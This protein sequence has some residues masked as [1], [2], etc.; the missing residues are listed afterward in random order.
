[1]GSRP[2][3]EW[4]RVTLA[5]PAYGTRVVVFRRVDEARAP[6][7]GEAAP[8]RQIAS[9]S[10]AVAEEG[11][12]LVAENA[13][14]RVELANGLIR[15]LSTLSRTSLLGSMNITEGRR[16][17]WPG[18]RLNFAKSV[19][20][21]PDVKRE[22]GKTIITFKGVLKRSGEITL[23][24]QTRYTLDESPVMGLD[25]V[26][27][28]PKS[29]RPVRGQLGMELQ[30]GEAGE[31][32]VNTIE[33]QLR[34]TYAVLHP[35]GDMRRGYR[36]WHRSGL[37][38]ESSL[39]PLDYG[40][41]VVAAKVGDRWL[42]VELPPLLSGFENAYLRERSG[43]GDEGLTL[44]LGWLEEKGRADLSKPVRASLRLRVG[45]MPGEPSGRISGEGWRFDSVSSR[46]E[47]RNEQYELAISRG[48]GGKMVHLSEPGG[49]SV[50]VSTEVYS[51]KGIY[52]P[53]KNSIGREVKTQGSSKNDFEPDAFLVRR[54]DGLDMTF[55]SFL[56]MSYW[57]WANVASPR[58]QYEV[59]YGLGAS[60]KIRARCRVRPMLSD[61]KLAAFLAQT[62]HI[63]KARRWSVD[64]TAGKKSGEAS[65]A[66][67][68][69]RVWQS[70]EAPL[71]RDGSLQIELLDGRRLTFSAIHA[72]P[73]EVQNVFLL[74]SGGNR[75]ILFIAFFDGTPAKYRPSWRSADY[76]MEL[77]KP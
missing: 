17:I 13:F 19:E 50:I 76:T 61:A 55:N 29:R 47:F 48:L 20:A 40:R 36:Y 24:W 9:K 65:A 23:P 43:S 73:G 15:E 26:L 10:V 70:R 27:D 63:A 22:G 25:I 3:R 58:V 68:G 46:Y 1:M 35:L 38:W 28:S 45:A 11:D 8:K 56:R 72:R 30:F 74:D 75:M 6:E 77:I 64:T 2:L 4:R 14:Y 71:A 59:R 5:V 32:L 39:F 67:G 37:L 41:P 44:Y 34:D 18:E 12:R 66:R 31:W 42:S 53:R 57:G 21:K 62:L 54:A 33:G 16:K 60:P 69:G 49:E 7:A 51:D 52:A